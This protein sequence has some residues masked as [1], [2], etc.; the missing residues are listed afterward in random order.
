MKCAIRPFVTNGGRRKVHRRCKVIKKNEA[1]DIVNTDPLESITNRLGVVESM[2]SD[3]DWYRLEW[4]CALLV[5]LVWCMND[6]RL[7]VT[8]R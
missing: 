5:E 7:V 6:R 2:E 1:S 3:Q 8:L 4:E